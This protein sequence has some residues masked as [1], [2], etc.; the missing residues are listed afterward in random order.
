MVEATRGIMEPVRVGT[1]CKP[2]PRTRAKTAGWAWTSVAVV[3]LRK[4]KGRKDIDPSAVLDHITCEPL[5]VGRRA[6]LPTT[7]ADW[8]LAPFAIPDGVFL[9]PFAG[10]GALTDAAA[11]AGM[12]AHGFE[13]APV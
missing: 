8:A 1:W 4:G 11:R 10:S 9:D 2:T 6:Q 3:A 12:T 13:K 7:V 5:R